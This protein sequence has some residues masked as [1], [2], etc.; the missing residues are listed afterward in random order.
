MCDSGVARVTSDT[1]FEARGALAPRGVIRAPADTTHNLVLNLQNSQDMSWT[2]PTPDADQLRSSGLRLESARDLDPLLDRIGDARYVLLGEASHGTSEYY[3]WRAEITKRLITE[4]GF[5]FI[6]VEG[7][8]PDC[9]RVNRYVKAYSH[10]GESAESVLHE[11]ERW[12]TWMWAN[13]EIVE[14][15]EWLRDYNECI[16]AERKVGFYGL[17]VYSL[18]DSMH[19]VVDYLE[20]IDPALA[21]GARRAYRCFDPYGEDVQEYA[22]AT[23]L[24]PT[25]CENEVVAVLRELRARAT[26]YRDDG[27]ESYFNAEQ[28]ALVAR[29]AELYYRTMVRGGPASWNVRDNHMVET[30]ERLMH[31]YGASAKAIVW[32]HNTH[33]G[34]ARYTDM[35]R[36]GMVN[37]GQLV[38]QAHE[39]DGVVLV[40]FGSHHGSVIAG[41]EWGAPMRRMMVPPARSESW[42]AL[43]HEHLGGD[44]LFVFNGDTD[45]GIRGLDEAIDHRAIGVVYD[46]RREKWGN[47]VPTLMPLRYD[48]FLYVDESRALDPLH[49]PAHVDH[50]A[51]ETFPSGM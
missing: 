48:A 40:G 42:E 3:T 37:V 11:Y 22:R 2:C 18:W 4:K 9:Y 1:R 10:S 30:L 19:A 35:A 27:R 29:N 24:V 41:D 5:S 32:E 28:N 34:D 6:G 47:Y 38:R 14:L 26:Q 7:D 44:A 46:P 21:Q 31:H 13:R 23:Y 15:A 16:G 25:D 20:R 36:A 51:P 50:E 43:C 12:P 8:W 49:M 39:R 45:G 17:D 33:I